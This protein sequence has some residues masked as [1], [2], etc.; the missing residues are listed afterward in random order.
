MKNQFKYIMD[1]EENFVRVQTTSDIP[2][3]TTSPVELDMMEVQGKNLW[4][5]EKDEIMKLV[6]KIV[7]QK[8]GGKTNTNGNQG[9]G[10][11]A[12]YTP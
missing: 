3:D 5:K 4:L 6:K 9:G 10:S 7:D 11:T 2:M 8:I 12:L 1:K